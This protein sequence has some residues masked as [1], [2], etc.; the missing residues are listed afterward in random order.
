MLIEKAVRSE[1]MDIIRHERKSKFFLPRKM[2]PRIAR[3][4]PPI[5]L[6]MKKDEAGRPVMNELAHSR[7]H[8]D[9]IVF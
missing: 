6:P 1:A 5:R 4:N 3:V 8:S 2:S 9:M 7:P